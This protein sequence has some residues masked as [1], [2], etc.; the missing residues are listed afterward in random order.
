MALWR[1]TGKFKTNPQNARVLA[2]DCRWKVHLQ[3]QGWLHHWRG[4]L[5]S[6]THHVM[7]VCLYHS[8]PFFTTLPHFLKVLQ[9]EQ[10]FG[11]SSFWVLL[12]KK[13]QAAKRKTVS[14][15]LSDVLPWICSTVYT[16]PRIVRKA[17]FILFL[18]LQSFWW[19]RT[20]MLHPRVF[21]SD[22]MQPQRVSLADICDIVTR[23]RWQALPF[24][25]FLGCHSDK[26]DL[27]SSAPC[28]AMAGHKDW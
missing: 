25:L 12:Q 13:I 2:G 21:L 20:H 15:G 26:A 23:P 1:Q 9:S 28:I 19:N 6:S 7:V 17:Y 5:W 4:Q 14:H 16:V 18:L 22:W 27:S 11:S 24:L 10:C 3:A 8:L